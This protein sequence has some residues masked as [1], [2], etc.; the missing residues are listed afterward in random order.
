[1]EEGRW[2]RRGRGRLPM[3]ERLCTCGQIQT[4]KHVIEECPRS[5]HLRQKY[6]ISTIESLLR[7]RTDYLTTCSI[8]HKILALY[9]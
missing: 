6:N 5:L 9:T 7:E 1:M 8:V 3:D 4:E 2:N